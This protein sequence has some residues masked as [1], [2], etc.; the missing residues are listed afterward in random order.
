MPRPRF[1]RID[2]TDPKTMER[3]LRSGSVWQR[4]M[5]WPDAVKA[6]RK[7]VVPLDECPNVPPEVRD[8]LRPR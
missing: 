5:F 2:L 6:I 7:G 1:I 3:M 8:L 4:Q